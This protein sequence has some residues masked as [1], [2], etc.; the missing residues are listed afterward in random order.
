MRPFELNHLAIA[1]TE[2]PAD[3]TIHAPARE[4]RPQ[5]RSGVV[6]RFPVKISHAA[7]VRL[8]DESGK[9]IPAGSSASLRATGAAVPVGYDG[10]AYVEDLGP[11]NEMT[12]ELP[13][14]RHCTAI[15][16][17][18]PSPGNIPTIG[19]VRCVEQRP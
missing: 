12:I 6:V 10:E 13:D 9:A 5:D 1:T 18:R 3:V 19:P 17:Y 15:F 14:G 4:V 11:L 7:L 2:L 16:E 8:V